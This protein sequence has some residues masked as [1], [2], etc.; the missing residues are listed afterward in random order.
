MPDYDVIV[1]GGGLGGLSSGALLARQGRRVLVLEQSSQVGGCC[2]TFEKD[3]FHFDVGASIVEII[4]PIEKVFKLLG[5]KLQEEID[6][7]SCDPI[8]TY[9]FENGQRI[10][11]PLSA[12]KTGLRSALRLPPTWT[13]CHRKRHPLDVWNICAILCTRNVRT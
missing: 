3:G 7:I 5:V 9:L 8:M 1:I 6:L 12:E 13:F 10:T 2:S 4:Q 11:Y